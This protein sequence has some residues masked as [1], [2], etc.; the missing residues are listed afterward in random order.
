MQKQ[1]LVTLEQDEDGFF[2]VSCPMLKGCHSQGRTEEEAIANIKEAI[3]GYLA[4][5]EKHGEALPE[6][7]LRQVA[8]EV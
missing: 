6:F 8:V 1:F 5:M 4:S 2:V 7:I 3:R